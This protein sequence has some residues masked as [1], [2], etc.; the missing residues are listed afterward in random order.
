MN[1]LGGIFLKKFFYSEQQ[2]PVPYHKLSLKPVSETD[3]FSKG[4]QKTTKP[5]KNTGH[6]ESE[7]WFLGFRPEIHLKVGNMNIL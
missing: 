6:T 2:V 3:M 1:I 4:L 5:K 7:T